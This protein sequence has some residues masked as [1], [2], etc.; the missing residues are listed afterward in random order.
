LLARE[1]ARKLLT[2]GNS[3]V[4]PFADFQQLLWIFMAR[5]SAFS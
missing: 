4:A 3:Q 1:I 5:R 2:R